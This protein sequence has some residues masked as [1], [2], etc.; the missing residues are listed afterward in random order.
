M[1]SITEKSVRQILEK[2]IDRVDVQ[3]IRNL[4]KDFD[5]SDIALCLKHCQEKAGKGTK[6]G[7]VHQD[8]VNILG[9][10]LGFEVKFGDHLRGADG[11]WSCGDVRIVIESKTSATWLGLLE[12]ARKFVNDEKA[13]CGLLVSASFGQETVNAVRGGYP[14]LRLVTTDGLCKL[15]QLRKEGILGIDNIVNILVP[16]E[17]YT[18]DGLID[19]VYGIKE[20]IKRP[21]PVEIIA[22]E[23]KKLEEVPESIKDYDVVAKAMYAILR[24]RSNEW[25]DPTELAQEIKNNFPKTFNDKTVGQIAWGFP[26]AGHWLEKKGVLEIKRDEDG[27]RSYRIKAL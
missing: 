22:D 20:Q 3:E 11:V 4:A 17:T 12:E 5:V 19:L 6:H 8:L 18:L 23:Q 9:E 24:N 25:I 13:I 14:E 26:F 1:S 15:A 27:R 2:L 7:F 10:R 16:Q 21:Q